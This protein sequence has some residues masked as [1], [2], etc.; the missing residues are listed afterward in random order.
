MKCGRIHMTISSRIL[1]KYHSD[2]LRSVQYLT[3]IPEG[4]IYW[5]SWL[6]YLYSEMAFA[7][8]TVIYC[9]LLRWIA[10]RIYGLKIDVYYV[11][12]ANSKHNIT[13]SEIFFLWYY[14]TYTNFHTHIYF[15]FEFYTCGYVSCPWVYKERWRVPRT[16]FSLAHF[17][18]LNVVLS[19]KPHHYIHAKKTYNH[20]KQSYFE[21]SLHMHWRAG[22]MRNFA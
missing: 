14:D 4:I 6:K 13:L 11:D 18:F 7:V 15:Y 16:E 17:L 1:H 3:N 10:V 2:T 12:S 22:W 19:L 5:I 8:N 21:R 9:T 20:S